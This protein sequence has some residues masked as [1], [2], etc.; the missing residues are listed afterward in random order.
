[1]LWAKALPGK[2]NITKIKPQETKL[3]S[4]IDE[5]VIAFL[6]FNIFVLLVGLQ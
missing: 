4:K 6:M 5:T 2:Q 3:L 1:L